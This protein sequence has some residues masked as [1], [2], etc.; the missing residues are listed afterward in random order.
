MKLLCLWL[1]NSAGTTVFGPQF[2][3]FGSAA[4]AALLNVLSLGA[5]GQSRFLLRKSNMKHPEVSEVGEIIR[6]EVYHK[7]I[8]VYTKI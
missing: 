7:S 2:L 6:F 5:H 1:S 8:S 4:F 3:A